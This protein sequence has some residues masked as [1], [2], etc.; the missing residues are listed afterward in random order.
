MGE[1]ACLRCGTCC[2]WSGHVLLQESDIRL[3][4]DWLGLSERDFIEVYCRLAANRAQ[5]SLKEAPDGTCIFLKGNDCRI[6]PVRP[7][8]C[9][10]FPA[11][12]SVEGCPVAERERVTSRIGGGGGNG[13]CIQGPSVR[14]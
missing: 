9:R 3:M 14:S 1:F 11:V 5:L 8:Q 10:D 4:A 12:W 7:R 6:Y 13:G 2:R